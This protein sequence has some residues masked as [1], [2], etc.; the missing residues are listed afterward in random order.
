MG[1][2]EQRF[3]QEA[4]ATNWVAP[5]GPNVDGFESDIAHYLS[6]KGGLL[7]VAALSSGTAAIHLALSLLG[8]GRD[9]I[10][11]CQ[12]FTFCGSVNPAIYQG[13]E[14]VFIDSEK[15]SWNM[16]PQA[17][18]DA[19]EALAASGKLS[20]V[21]AII[22][23]HLY[24]MPCA[25]DSIKAVADNYGIPIVEDA[26]EALGSSFKG[27]KC[28]NFGALAALS[29]NGNKIITTSGGGALVSSNEQH[30]SRAKFLSTQARD[31]AP[32]YQ[33]SHVGYNYRL[34]NVLAGIGRGQMEVLDERVAARRKNH[35]RYAE[36]FR[37]IPCVT[38]HEEPS[39]DYF[40]NYWLTGILIDSNI[41]QGVDRE[42]LRLALQSQ[43]I[44]A[45]PLW[46]PM[47]LQPL[48]EGSRFFGSGVCED[49]FEKG[50]CLPS[51]SNLTD[52]DFDRIFSCMDTVFT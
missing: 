23:V 47:H 25:I 20:R 12:S 36:Y 38:M 13:A 52:A 6:P 9:D 46:K 34:S 39:A 42:Q 49:L 10:I 44:E 41:G 2:G 11:L 15:D 45:R 32:H 27:V 16:C 31:E 30:I 7:H 17:L 24:G 3:V 28:G 43:Q 14:V 35:F 40:S 8:V 33:H 48:F 50:L 19:I 22:P 1:S 29:F 37:N 18:E 51:G 4:F 5:M 21:K 26:A